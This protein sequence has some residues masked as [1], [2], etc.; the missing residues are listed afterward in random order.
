MHHVLSTDDFTREEV[1]YLIERAEHL[2]R[3]SRPELA[4]RLRGA[5]VAT[6]F[7]EPSTRTRL[8]FE[9]AVAKLGGRVLA[10]ENA[11]ENTSAKKG[12]RLEDTFRVVGCYA[13]AIVIRHHDEQEMVRAAGKSPVPIVNAGAGAGEHPTQALLDVYTLWREL[14]RIDGLRVC[15]MGDLKYGRTVHSLLKML[16]YFRDIDVT[17]VHPD[18]LALPADLEAWLRERGL[19]MARERDM[20]AALRRSDAI[21]QTRIQTERVRS[22]DEVQEASAYVIRPEHLSLLQPGARILHPLPRVNEIDMEV[23]E[24]ERAAYFRQAENGLYIRMALLE[25]LLKEVVR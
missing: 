18:S 1:L 15:I 16:T 19:K 21:Y 5:V 6:L 20:A 8:S 14:G 9:A 4:V 17:L 11:R 22:L 10:A 24:D 25:E 3:L 13:D 12:E 23:D 7:Y 2:R